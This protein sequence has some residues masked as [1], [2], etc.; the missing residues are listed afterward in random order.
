MILILPRERSTASPPVLLFTHH[1]VEK[2]PS[3]LPT[4]GRIISRFRPLSR[5][6]LPSDAGL[7]LS[8]FCPVFDSALKTQH[9]FSRIPVSC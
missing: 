6:N 1:P 2:R 8:C 5:L 7:S 4:E 3:F 9:F